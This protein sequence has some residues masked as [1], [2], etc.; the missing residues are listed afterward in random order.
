MKDI[1]NRTTKKQSSVGVQPQIIHR[2]AKH[3]ELNTA[4]G[5][6]PHPGESPEHVIKQQLSLFKST[7]LLTAWVRGLFVC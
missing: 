4:N 3:A 2:G 5:E 6:L 1:Y 7:S